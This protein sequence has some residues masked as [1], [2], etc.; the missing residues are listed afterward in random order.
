MKFPVTTD[1][2][3]TKIPDLVIKFRGIRPEKQHDQFYLKF[4][5][6]YNRYLEGDNVLFFA[7]LSTRL[8]KISDFMK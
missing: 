8:C 3:C 2:N 1:N 7:L 5:D 6:N 4:L